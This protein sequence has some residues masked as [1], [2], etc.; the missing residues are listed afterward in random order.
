MHKIWQQR[1]LSRHKFI[2]VLT[3]FTCSCGYVHADLI[4]CIISYHFAKPPPSHRNLATLLDTTY[5]VAQRRGWRP[6]VLKEF[7][8]PN[9]SH[10]TK[11][12]QV[13][14]LQNT[15]Q[16]HN[17]IYGRE[18]ARCSKSVKIFSIAAH[19]DE[20]LHLKMPASDQ[21]S[22]CSQ[23]ICNK[24]Y[25][26]NRNAYIKSTTNQTTAEFEPKCVENN[27]QLRYA[28]RVVHKCERSE[29]YINLLQR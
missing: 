16:S 26:T 20:R 29:W 18:T 19:L 15:I 6:T 3:W 22:W 17:R 8:R 12:Y 9:C 25:T 2:C 21:W 10:F 27:P 11:Q 23:Q 14:L 28:P 5:Y 13:G 1:Y 7:L 4:Q 24:L